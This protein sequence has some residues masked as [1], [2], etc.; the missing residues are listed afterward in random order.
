M[1]LRR[2]DGRPAKVPAYRRMMPYLMRGRN[3][4]VVYFE[5][6][7]D[8]SR[9]LPWI[10]AWNAAAGQKASPFHLVLHAI[11]EVLHERPRLNRFVVGRRIHDRDGVYLSFAAKKQMSDDGALATVKRRFAQGEPFAAMMASLSGAIGE[12][13]SDR[14]SAVDKELKVLLRLPRPVLGGVLRL[15]HALDAVHLAPRVMLD[16]DPMYA[17]AFLANLGSIKIDAAYHHLYEHGN[18]PLFIA[19]GKVMPR[20]VVTESGGV[21]ARPTL[22]LRYSYDERVEDGH[23]CARALDL[24]K[25][26]VEDP[27]AYIS[28]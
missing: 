25:A 18:C 11:G 7:L 19:V 8:L 15:F 17:S 23:Y 22:L 14:A 2:S 28:A 21:E 6:L 5:Q 16:S 24:L 26:R 9:T 12:A 20:P 3:E 1:L 13:R 10:E 4:S 27:S